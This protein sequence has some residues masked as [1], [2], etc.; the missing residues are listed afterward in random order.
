MAFVFGFVTFLLGSVLVAICLLAIPGPDT[1][2]QPEAEH[3]HGH[4]HGH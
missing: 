3:G 1:G 2:E 4:G